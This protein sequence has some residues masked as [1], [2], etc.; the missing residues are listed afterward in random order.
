MLNNVLGTTSYM[1]MTLPR[2]INIT[3]LEDEKLSK[4]S[5]EELTYYYSQLEY[6]CNIKKMTRKWLKNNVE[7]FRTLSK[8]EKEKLTKEQLEDYYHDMRNY[9]LK[10]VDNNEIIR[11]STKEENSLSNI[12]YLIYLK[13]LRLHDEASKIMNMNQKSRETIHPLLRTLIRVDRVLKGIKIKKLNTEI[14]ES[15]KNRRKIFVVTHV[16][17]DDIAV[18]NEVVKS[19]TT[20]LSGDYESLH[21]N[22]EGLITMLNK[23]IFFDMKSSNE[24]KTIVPRVSNELKR[25]NDILCSMEAAWNLYSA[26]LVNDLFPGMVEASLSSE[27]NAVIVPVGIERFNNKLFGIN[28]S[29]DY[30]DAK[31][32]FR[33]KEVNR[34]NMYLAAEEVR[35]LLANAKFELYFHPEIKEIITTTRDKI[36]DF[37]K[38]NDKFKNDILKNWTFTEEIVR[39][40]SFQNKQDPIIAFSYLKTMCDNL[41]NKELDNKTFNYNLANIIG[42]IKSNIYPNEIKNYMIDT[43]SNIQNHELNIGEAKKM[44]KK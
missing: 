29:K 24:R 34:E 31:E 15:I 41:K 27:A 1:D 11:L 42:C 17:A 36:G 23:V 38:Y 6:Y 5:F 26:K 12:E 28:I 25:G 19:R 2:D 20:I 22:I 43:L 33:S 35:Q 10:T 18:F 9:Y 8:E 30:F 3:I 16:G 37:D 7:L 13:D 44:I 14:P 4:M 39:G 40:K 21:N 32:Y